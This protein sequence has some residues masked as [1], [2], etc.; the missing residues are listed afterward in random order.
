MWSLFF[1]S[2]F[3]STLLYKTSGIHLI[4]HLGKNPPAMQE[5]LVPFLG[6]EDRLEKG[7]ATHS[8]IQA[9]RIPW[10]GQSM[11]SPRVGCLNDLHLHFHPPLSMWV[12]SHVRLFVTSWT[13]AHR[14]P[15]SMGFSRQEYWSGLLFPTP[16]DLP[17]P[18][19]KPKRS[20]PLCLLYWQANSSPL[21]HLGSPSIHLLACFCK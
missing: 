15:L 12:L 17:D 6:W 8:S 4:P 7:K 13:V 10:T 16:G 2:I 21:S 9:W 20:N 19:I 11:A 14:A 5:T 18:G 1:I 3:T